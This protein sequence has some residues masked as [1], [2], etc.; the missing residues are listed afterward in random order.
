MKRINAV[1][2]VL[3]LVLVLSVSIE[4]AWAYFTTYAMARVTEA[5]PIETSENVPEPETPETPDTPENPSNPSTPGTPDTPTPPGPNPPGPN[6]PGPNPPGP[7]PP[8]PNPPSPPID[9][10]P[11]VDV[12]EDF[13]D[14]TKRITI[15]N[16]GNVPVYVRVWA[17]GPDEYQ[18][19]TY[20]QGWKESGT[21]R[22]FYY[23]GDDTNNG[24]LEPGESTSVLYV[25]I[26]DV[27]N[28]DIEDGT[29][30]DVV[31]N[32]EAIT[33]V[34]GGAGPLAD[35]AGWPR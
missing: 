32:Y 23:V 20:G 5:L 2:C 15:T 12:D 27:P 18:L 22:Q 11:D 16:T 34:N 7:N 8:G 24:V 14:W 21:R 17:T 33:V 25:Q 3:A 19:Y 30:F 26:N 6:P 13:S 29:T 35:S 31:V 28:D 9:V 1:L 10:D 4:G